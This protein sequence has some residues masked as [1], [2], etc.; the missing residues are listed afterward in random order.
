MNTLEIKN[1]NNAV[2]NNKS[3]RDL[4]PK[5]IKEDILFFKDDILKD[6]KKFENRLNIKCEGQASMLKD[7][8]DK[9]DLK[10]EAMTEKISSLG[11]KISTN[12]SLKEKVE[13]L[14][15]FKNKIQGNIMTQDVRIDTIMKDLKN[16]INK[17]DNILLESVIYSG[18][19]GI[20]ARF[21]TFHELIDFILININQLNSFKEKNSMDIKT[22]KKKIETLSQN[23][24]VQIESINKNN[25]EYNNRGLQETENKINNYF[26]EYNNKLIQVRME[27]N[28]YGI[29]LE[30]KANLLNEN[31]KKI[32]KLKFDMEEKVK[33]EINK[34]GDIS[35]NF[36]LRFDNYQNE[37]NTIKK[38][39]IVLSEFIKN[40][41][42][43][44]METKNF[45]SKIKFNKKSK[46]F[47]KKES[48][49]IFEQKIDEKDEINEKEK[50]TN[51]KMGT[52]EVPL[53]KQYI[54]GDV[55]LKELCEDRK[56]LLRKKSLSNL[57]IYSSNLS[58]QNLVSITKE[59]DFVINK[60]KDENSGKEQNLNFE[61]NIK[62]NDSQYTNL[63]LYN[64]HN[65]NN[66]YEENNNSIN[67]ENK[68]IPIYIKISKKDIK[69]LEKDDIQI[70]AKA[71][72][73]ENKENFQNSN[74]KD[75]YKFKIIGNK[76][77]QYKYDF[78]L[79]DKN[80]DLIKRF[81]SE[82]DLENTA[83]TGII[84]IIN[85][86][87]KKQNNNS[88]DKK[89]NKKFPILEYKK[90]L[91]NE[92][93]TDDKKLFSIK[94]GF[95]K[96]NINK[97]NNNSSYITEKLSNT[98]SIPRKKNLENNI[99]FFKT[100][101]NLNLKQIKDIKKT[102]NSNSFII[103][104]KLNKNIFELDNKKLT[105]IRL[106][107]HNSTNDVIEK[108]INEIE[109]CYDEDKKMEK[110]IEKIKE[111]IPYEDKISLSDRAN[112]SKLN[113]N[114]FSKKYNLLEQNKKEINK[115]NNLEG[116]ELQKSDKHLLKLNTIYNKQK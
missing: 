78:G 40:N 107:G 98:V 23:L 91:L 6:I 80:T 76:V 25:M 84:S 26:E 105:P 75:D 63:K 72:K 79:D 93:A 34:I 66:S 29:S 27:N 112:A 64:K 74:D 96:I 103:S 22:Y 45:S 90:E 61:K 9:Y 46:D 19:I 3:V 101:K 15:E 28:Q 77:Y 33:Y 53:L 11:N 109:L 20:N 71:Y 7:K 108:R 42:P 99:Y 95:V 70:N 56:R 38:R 41:K 89:E 49:E 47:I 1:I 39:F 12:I 16:A 100:N 52:P 37:F 14:Y 110:L 85:F 62:N 2:E 82:N 17:Y 111:I 67:N 8:F 106:K 97:N 57:P 87:H 68:D 54:H 104:E 30:E 69:N 115:V 21:K 60:E 102:N 50:L 51:N 24:K 35:E 32:E 48:R 116:K 43:Q 73:S 92:E 94:N 58:S 114:I 55:N 31:F 44:N 83:N 113:K 65:L 18:I 4:T 10:M 59:V 86:G 13:E 81:S 36:C 88:K 5:N